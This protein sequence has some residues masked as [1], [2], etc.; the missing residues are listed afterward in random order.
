MSI[1]DTYIEIIVL[2]SIIF[3]ICVI[4]C[5]KF[6]C[7]CKSDDNDNDNDNIEIP[8]PVLSTIHEVVELTEVIQEKVE[9][10]I[11]DIEEE[12]KEEIEI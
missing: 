1:S 9:L 6:C 7:W 8:T 5:I 11:I 4:G 10:Q 2:Y 3:I 12:E